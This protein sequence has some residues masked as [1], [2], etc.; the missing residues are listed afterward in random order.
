MAPRVNIYLP[1]DI[2]EEVR[3]A[4]LNVSQIAQD[5]L[6]AELRR[7]ELPGADGVAER[8]RRTLDEDE[9]HER[10]DYRERGRAWAQEAAT[11]RELEDL[12]R[13]E[14]GWFRWGVPED[15]STRDYIVDEEVGGDRDFR[16]DLERDAL[17]DAFI[18]GALE[19]WEQVRGDVY[20]PKGGEGS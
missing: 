6:R 17:V 13:M 19:V 5:A 15:H 2:A 16:A 11:V 4:S 9:Q 18:D 20:G 3:G 12:G 7:R 10:D 1:A 14:P 8:L